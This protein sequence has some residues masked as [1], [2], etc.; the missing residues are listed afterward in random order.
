[1]PTEKQKLIQKRADLVKEH[2]GLAEKLEKGE[3][4]EEKERERAAAIKTEI[5]QIDADIELLTEQEEFER[6]MKP[7]EG[8]AASINTLGSGPQAS[9]SGDVSV[10]QKFEDDPKKGFKK[11]RDFFV[12][13]KKYAE[14]HR[15]AMSDPRMKL[16]AVV[17]SDEHGEHSDP[18]V[19]FL[20]PEGFLNN[21][22][23]IEPEQ[24]TIGGLTRKVPMAVPIVN[25]PSRVDKDHSTSVSGG[26]VVTRKAHTAEGSLSK[27][28][29]E[30]VTLHAHDLFGFAAA[31]ESVLVDSPQSVAQLISDGF[32]DE[33]VSKLI[34]ERLTGTGNGEYL[35]I[36]ES[37]ALIAVAGETGQEPSSIIY[38]NI[39]NM[40]RRMW[41]YS[42]AVWHYNHDAL[43]YLPLLAHPVGTG[44]VPV[45]QPSARVD[46]PETIMGRPAYPT[47]Y[48]PGLGSK[49]VLCCVNWREY[50]EG[51]LQPLQSAESMHVR[52]MNHERV[53]KFWERN[54]G[55]PWWRSY[56]TPK[57]GS[58]LSPY[59]VLDAIS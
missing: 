8:A 21:L 10:H 43:Q 16:L 24:D 44:G 26:L 1:M 56:L 5:G 46:V 57:N 32:G 20:I 34:Q 40:R 31:E 49:G 47:E 39:I 29:T 48:L 28:K 35:G 52:F 58:T 9:R 45:W 4:L 33:F 55:A 6:T 18:S 54:D 30:L 36:L 23:R 51:T 13:V 12:Q 14:G 7:M 3:T 42:D 37:D 59:V 17:G 19:N 11:P 38:E 25:I 27:M 2:K 15:D 53:F 50:L 41:R 22:L